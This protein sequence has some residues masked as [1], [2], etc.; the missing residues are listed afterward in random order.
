MN[1]NLQDFRHECY[2]LGGRSKC[3]I[4]EDIDCDGE[5][6]TCHLQL[7]GVASNYMSINIPTVSDTSWAVGG[8]FKHDYGGVSVTHYCVFI[9]G[10]D[11]I[12]PQTTDF[13]N[14]AV[15]CFGYG[16]H[17]RP[18]KLTASS[19]SVVDVYPGMG[20]WP[21]DGQVDL[22][23]YPNNC[24]ALQIA[25]GQNAC[26]VTENIPSYNPQ[27]FTF[28]FAGSGAPGFIDGPSAKA[29]F[30]EPEDV[31]VDD[32][33][34]VYVAD[35]GNHA[36][37]MIKMGVV[38][39]IAGNGS[40]YQGFQ[41][42][43]CHLATFS[44]PKGLDVRNEV[45]VLK[46]NVTVNAT[47]ILVADT[48]NNRIRRIDYIPDNNTCTVTCLTG[49]CGVNTLSKTLTESQA[50]PLTGYADGPG[51]G[52]R[53]SS[54]ESVSFMNSEYFAIADT[55]NFLIRMAFVSN[56][57][58]FTLAGSVISGQKDPN[59]NPLAGCTPPCLVGEPGYRD[60]NL[61][62]AQFYNPLDVTRGPNN[63]LY[64]IDEQRLRVIELPYVITTLYSVK[65]EARVSTIAGTSIQGHADGFG[66]ESSFYHS[67][68]VFVTSDN[69]AYVLD[70]ITCRVRRV[71]PLPLV[72]TPITCSTK[73]TD[74]IRPSGCTSF[75]QPIDEIGRKIS[76]VEANV[77]Y[78]YGWPYDDD[79]DRGKY[80]KNCVGSPPHDTLDKHF[81]SEGDNLVVDD[82]RVAINED[83]EQGTAIVITCPSDCSS[84]AGVVEG[85]NWYSEGSSI[86]LAAVHAG[87]LAP[88]MGGIIQILLQRRDY[89]KDVN[90]TYRLG[91]TQHNIVSTDIPL[92]THRVFSTSL[93]NLSNVM[94]HTV[95]GHPSAP[96]ESECGYA[97]AQPATAAKF[98]TPSGIAAS[99]LQPL[100]QS[101]YLYIADTGNNRI[102]AISAVCTQICENGAS[103]VGPDTCLCQPGWSGIDCTIPSC[104]SNS[105]G[106]N[107]VC[108]APDTC[109]CK[110][111]YSGANCDKPL[112][113][114]A[115]LN[116]GGC[117]APDT[118]SC[119]DGWFDPQCSTPVCSVTCANGG[120]CTAPNTCACP[121]EW[122]NN[123]CRTPVCEQTC[124]NGGL[125]IAPNTCICPPE[126]IN[127]D[128]SAP[129]C[130]QGYF[131]PFGS[132][133]PTYKNCD[134][135]SWCNATNE[136]ECD[137]LK[138]SYGIIALPSGPAYRMINGRKTQPNQCMNIELS[139]SYKIPYQLLRSDGTTTGFPRFSPNTP[140]TS[141]DRNPWRGFVNFTA[142]HT[143]PWTY[144]P[145]RQVPNV[146]WLNVSQGV[147]V[148]A[149]GGSCLTPGV[150]ACASGWI[151]FDCRTPVCDQGYFNQNQSDY[152]SGLKTPDEIPVFSRFMDNRTQSFRLNWPY[153][154][155]SFSIEFEDLSV[156]GTVRRYIQNYPGTQYLNNFLDQNGKF[157]QGGYRCTIRAHT[158]WENLYHLFNHPNFYSRYMDKRR[159][160]DN[161]TY[162]IWNGF[163]WPPTHSKSRV[164]DQYALN[165]SY[166]F[167]KEG[168]RRLGIWN[169]TGN[170]YKLGLCVVEFFRN[171]SVPKKQLDLYS[172]LVGV[173]VQDTD[174]SYRPQISYS[175]IRV[176]SKGRW[177]E[178]GGQCV[179]QVIRGCHNNGTCIGP[180]TCRCAP[181]WTGSDCSTPLCSQ[182]C[183]H[184]GNCTAPDICTCE[185]GWSGFDCSTPLCAQECNNGG[186]CVA[187]DTCQC[188]QWENSFRD[189]QG[190]G[191]QPLFQDENGD[192]LASGWTGYD[193]STP[194]CVQAI[195]FLRNVPTRTSHGFVP[196][197][198]HGADTLLTCTD[199]S[200]GLTLPRCPQFDPST[201]KSLS[202]IF[203]TSN[204]GQSFQTG[205]GWDPFDT[206]CC[207]YLSDQDVVCYK[208]DSNIVQTSNETFFCGG[209]Y[210]PLYGK[211]TDT[212][213]FSAF[214]DPF[215]N[216]KLCGKYH[217]PRD[218][219]YGN[220]QSNYGKEKYYYNVL[221]PKYSSFNFKS[222]WTSNRFLCN[223]DVWEQGDYVDDAGL[224][225]IA[226]A[227]SV[228][229]LSYGR[230][231][232]INTPNIKVSTSS[233]GS[234]V[235][236]RGNKIRGEGVYQCANNGSCI[237]PDTCTCSDGYTGY[238]CSTPLCR[239]LQPSK[240]VTSCL[241]GGFCVKK[242][243][244]NCVQVD[245]KIWMVHPETNRGVTGW[246]GSDCTMP[247][248]VQGFYDP[249]CTDL[250][251]APGGE[252][253]YRCANGGN[254]TAPDVCTCAEG[255][256]GYD[257]RT[258]ICT[259]VADPLTRT[260]LGTAYEDKVI[261]FESD[262]C[263]VLAIYGMRGWKGQKYSRG[264]CTLPNQ[265]TCLCRIPYNKKSCRKY[266][267][268]C[269]GPWQDNM[270]QVRNV[271]IGRGPQYS[272]GST[273]CAFG[274]EGNVDS[275]D[276]FM[277]CHLIIYVPSKNEQSSLTLIIIFS[278]L[279]FFA[280][281]GYRYAYERV[282]RRFLLAKIERRRYENST[283]MNS[284]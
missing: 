250:P 48:G 24:A 4:C 209:S 10:G 30:N 230:H 214:L 242:D 163:H 80:I 92:S 141:D 34:V 220:H 36:I 234:K 262:P 168:F 225:S 199:T 101:S 27:G 126:Y 180:N 249:Y 135:Q 181:K 218:Y 206:G 57:T 46:P 263:G 161:K 6:G 89:M 279:G 182:K 265:C 255:W 23:T 243:F 132:A 229:G 282:R 69:I 152:V 111:G 233:T 40:A 108:V 67:S 118:C 61:T 223:V 137:Q 54:P 272:F 15:R 251:Q 144:I 164:L 148:C 99:Y 121:R 22:W 39:T 113:S 266:R 283:Q 151:G 227:G 198:G 62:F 21:D 270:V 186:V 281:V 60:G 88:S 84:N 197:G 18:Q 244:C 58:T 109:A 231:I 178:A 142:N 87:V 38:T 53:F 215:K 177:K 149:N 19:R 253:C 184:N 150:C 276:R 179:D 185:V 204:D 160:A 158:E 131:Q 134:M 157:F 256:T 130:F 196:M 226:G 63:T 116:G 219:S 224:G 100:S 51:A 252:G 123:D 190:A 41:D 169:T 202:N 264:N 245:S 189:G 275:M 274:Y 86:C 259:M 162:T 170:P 268:L 106:V 70:S 200:T 241:N 96:L 128:C 221:Y 120:N 205:C 212:D 257:C 110:P 8:S 94:V 72:A 124:L 261:S 125:C 228:F 269:D 191:G 232:R 5:G 208:C 50:T 71:T 82:N 7:Q 175:D 103:C 280:I 187:P 117:T 188:K 273:D 64:V 102:R 248:C 97:E 207:V 260:Q 17:S 49:L 153:S 44:F 68:G 35:T 105:C 240:A 85:T 42:G 28:L 173:Y 76:R 20:R 278:V 12:L 29:Q 16:F 239:H 222:N 203:V 59:G 194:I 107:N 9:T 31:A 11:C 284:F 37:R 193:C 174:R 98:Q 213:K 165:F 139:T 1:S 114:K 79:L 159:Q 119:I 93:Y 3:H 77:Q 172:G 73:A 55:G 166:A 32:Y 95:A 183:Q 167:T 210:T 33:G 47:I 25:E 14:C 246:S 129:V 238:D 156:I 192:P 237:G 66:P 115:C 235:F 52:A 2:V 154:N 90:Y 277:S 138:M 145:D 127:Y 254:C 65:S 195:G 122:T 104:A 143:G 75:D 133:K 211:R 13:E 78:N 45:I 267:K 216:Y 146:N 271:L 201:D 140:Y 91:S 43:P 56:G 155:P 26:S 112:C 247:M 236:T 136:F 176:S 147:Y 217:S 258:P 83:S 81:I 74:V 171:C